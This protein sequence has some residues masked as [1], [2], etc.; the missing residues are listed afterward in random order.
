MK[1]DFD[2]LKAKM[3]EKY[4]SQNRFA[5]AFGTSENTMSRKMQSKTPF[6]RDDIVKI[7]DMLNIPKDQVGYYFLQKKFNNIKLILKNTTKDYHRN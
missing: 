6:S 2:A 1:F 7:C 4:G 3:I 5:E